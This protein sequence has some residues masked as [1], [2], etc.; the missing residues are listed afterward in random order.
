[1]ETGGRRNDA[2]EKSTK[3]KILLCKS[4]CFD[5]ASYIVWI[6]AG[7]SVVSEI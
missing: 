7:W 4:G 3:G 5:F 6:K 2:S 1:M